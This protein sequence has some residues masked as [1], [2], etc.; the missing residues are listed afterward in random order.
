MLSLC[1]YRAV[2]LRFC[3]S[4]VHRVCSEANH[5]C[6]T[7]ALEQVRTRAVSSALG[8]GIGHQAYKDLMDRLVALTGDLF[9][10][11]CV[12]HGTAAPA[13][14]GPSCRLK[15]ALHSSDA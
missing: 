12:C 7:G 11:R 13:L 10:S 6:G 1:A 9:E 8:G 4:I 3:L 15:P 5:G 14:P 2:F